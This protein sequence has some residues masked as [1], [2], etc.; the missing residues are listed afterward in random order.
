MP[1][2]VSEIIRYDRLI[3]GERNGSSECEPLN[4][5]AQIVIADARLF[6]K[7]LTKRYTDKNIFDDSGQCS[8]VESEF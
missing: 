2:L 3:W 1:Q 4:C 5:R 8:L 7:N 6:F